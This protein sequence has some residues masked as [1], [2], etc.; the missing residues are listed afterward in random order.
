MKISEEK[1]KVVIKINSS[2]NEIVNY[3]ETKKIYRIILKAKPIEGEAN[4]ELIKF[5]S[6]E[7]KRNVRIISGFRSKEKFIEFI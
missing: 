6:K 4:K 7:L 1:F 3:D 2:K 5:L